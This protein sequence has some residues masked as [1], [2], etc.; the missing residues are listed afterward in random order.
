MTVMMERKGQ[1]MEDFP[2]FNEPSGTVF[3]NFT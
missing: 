2:L 1:Q 3:S